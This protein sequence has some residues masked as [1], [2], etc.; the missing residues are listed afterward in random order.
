MNKKLLLAG[1]LFAMLAVLAGAFG[2]HGLKKILPPEDLSAY[3]TAVRYQMY[4]AMA[5]LF[6]ALFMNENNKKFCGIAGIL[7]SAGILFF[8]GSLYMITF[9][10]AVNGSVPFLVGIAA[11]LGGIMFA[12]GWAVLS[13][14][15]LKK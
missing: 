2:A 3:E 7:F 10:K 1:T 8:S 13:L 15:I 12:I 14:S 6:S 5:I 4:H 11:P 9:M